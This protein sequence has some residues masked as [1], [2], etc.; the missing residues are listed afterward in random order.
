MKSMCK[1]HFDFKLIFKV[2]SF[3]F[4]RKFKIKTID[5][6]NLKKLNEVLIKHLKNNFEPDLF[7][8]EMFEENNFIKNIEKFPLLYKLFVK[9]DNLK[10]KSFSVDYIHSSYKYNLPTGFFYNLRFKTFIKPNLELLE[11]NMKSNNVIDILNTDDSKFTFKIKS[12]NS[13]FEDLSVQ[14]TNFNNINLDNKTYGKCKTIKESKLFSFLIILKKKE[15][16]IDMHNDVSSSMILKYN[17]FKKEVYN[18]RFKLNS[19]II[20][21][22]IRNKLKEINHDSEHC[23]IKFNNS[24]IFCEQSINNILKEIGFD[25]NSYRMIRDF[26]FL[27][28]YMKYWNWRNRIAKFCILLDQ[29]QINKS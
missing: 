8:K 2:P 3:Y 21:K 13:L 5:E 19:I 17:G 25:S 4:A 26:M 18:D 6:N 16:N 22:S 11:E 20:K 24:D 29:N 10:N 1:Y 23:I 9:K 27:I 15:S 14:I 28:D 7:H 12:K